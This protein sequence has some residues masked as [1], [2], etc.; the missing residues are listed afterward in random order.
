M[1]FRKTKTFLGTSKKK[2]A[3]TKLNLRGTKKVYISLDEFSN[4]RPPDDC[5]SYENNSATFNMPSYYVK[6]TMGIEM[7]NG[8]AIENSN[9]WVDPDPPAGNC[10]KKYANK[11]L[12]SNLTSAQRYT[13]ENIRNAINF[14]KQNLNKS[15]VF[16]NLMYTLQLKFDT[17][18]PPAIQYTTDRYVLG[19]K[20]RE[21]F[22]PITLRKF[23]IRLFN[24]RGYEIDME[25]D[26]SFTLLIEQLYNN[27]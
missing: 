20:K 1:G 11:D 17:T 3:T 27:N 10:G 14:T 15:P 4:N 18:V 23:H 6:T 2:E 12:L 13:I 19:D 26:W 7:S 24:D 5:I 25:D 22:G 9:C 8:E 21:Y 16:P